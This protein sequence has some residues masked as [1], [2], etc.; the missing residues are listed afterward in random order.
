LPIITV[1]WR[2][3][4]LG[5]VQWRVAHIWPNHKGRVPQVSPLRRA[6][7]RQINRKWFADN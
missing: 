3:M 7:E 4:V 6:I 2:T 5:R 1:S